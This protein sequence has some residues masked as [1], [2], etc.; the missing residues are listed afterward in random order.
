MNTLFINESF[1]RIISAVSG[2]GCSILAASVTTSADAAHSFNLTTATIEDIHQAV[3]SGIIT[4]EKLID[5]YI[6]RIATYDQR[7]PALNQVISVNPRARLD[8]RAMDNELKEKGRRGPMHGIPVAVKDCIDTWDQPNSGG[9]L[10]LRN[11]FPPDDAFIVKKLREGGAIIL[12]KTNLSEFASGAPGMNGA[13]T[14]GG[15]PRNPYNTARHSDGSSSGSGGALAAVFATVALGTETG[16]STRGPAF[17]NN[18]VGLAPTEGLVSRDGVIPNSTTL[19]RVGLMGRY[20]ADVA[21]MLN[22]SI[23][24]DSADRITSLSDKYLGGKPYHLSLDKGSLKGARLGVFRSVFTSNDPRTLEARQITDRA[25]NELRA[26]GA[27]LIDPVG[28]SEDVTDLL[29]TPAIGPAELRDG[30]DGYFSSLGP[31]SSIKSLKDLIE[32]GGIIFNKFSSYK[33]ALQSGP[34]FEYPNY[35]RDIAKRAALRKQLESLMH[36]N[37]LDAI[38]YLHN[39]YPA[40]L[41]NELHP[42]TKVKLSS[43]S[44][45]PAIVVPAGFT[46]LNQPVGIEFLGKAFDERV[47]LSLAFSFEQNTKYRMLPNLTPSLSSDIISKL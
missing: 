27:V 25:L 47:I 21:T 42:Y 13:S 29:N 8:A 46:S 16:S 38:V 28:I 40:Q 41:I 9:A 10:S 4:Y 23:G 18:V 22:H 39:L 45:L 33:R 14:L 20:V 24:V 44:G 7:G 31:T 2:V 5:M 11:S 12:C 36:D 34:V 37:K 15:Q 35:S 30:L 6:E 43:V 17:H 3:D 19:D 26:A 1:W 32:D